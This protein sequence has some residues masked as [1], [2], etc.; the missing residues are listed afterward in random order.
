[1]RLSPGRRRTWISALV[2]SSLAL[3]Q[4][5]AL[6]VRW[7]QE[8]D[9]RFPAAD[10]VWGVTDDDTP[11]LIVPWP[12]GIRLLGAVEGRWPGDPFPGP[13]VCGD[14]LHI[15]KQDGFALTGIV[16][17]AL[18]TDE[19]LLVA[20]RIL[21]VAATDGTLNTGA[22][23]FLNMRFQD[24]AAVIDKIGHVTMLGDVPVLDGGVDVCVDGVPVFIDLPDVT[25]SALGLDDPH[26]D[27]TTVTNASRA[28]ASIDTILTEVQ[29]HRHA[30]ER[31][32][33]ALHDGPAAGGLLE[34]ERVLSR[35]RDVAWE[36]LDGTLS[37]AARCALEAQY[38][39]DLARIEAV[40]RNV[41]F[42]GLPLLDGATDVG[43]MDAPPIHTPHFVD[44]PD[45][46][47]TALGIAATRL[48]TWANAHAAVTAV[49]T[50]LAAVV[51][52][53]ERI[54]ATAHVL[55]NN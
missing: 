8:F 28:I 14:A 6:A 52:H 51:E 21:A 2:V 3:S 9:P 24:H 34:E 46:T 54:V 37:E 31:A 27:L 29:I 12:D 48:D 17:Q 53:R 13:D 26:L 11:I 38:A 25:G 10:A 39:Q 7:E 35:M 44:L 55:I 50:A 49:D 4:S 1:M 40:A 41:R 5:R 36:A 16:G 19:D 45:T 32:E 43:L 15:P 30:I 47:A 33:V 20:M 23:L 22:R 18:A 42:Q